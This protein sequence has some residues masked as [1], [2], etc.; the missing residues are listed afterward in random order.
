MYRAVCL[1]VC[2]S[3]CRCVTLSVGRSVGWQVGLCVCVTV[4]LFVCASVHVFVY[5]CVCL[6]GYLTREFIHF[7]MYDSISVQVKITSLLKRSICLGNADERIGKSHTQTNKHTHAHTNKIRT[8][9]R[10][11]V[12]TRQHTL[13]RKK[14]AVKKSATDLLGSERSST[15]RLPYC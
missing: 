2:R 1:S 5:V 3:V 12:R 13:C 11:D 9:P 10:T 7:S 14:A 15:Q 8:H 6:P 4:C